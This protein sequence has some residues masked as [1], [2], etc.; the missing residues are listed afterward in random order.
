M[1]KPILYD[2]PSVNAC[3][4]VKKEKKNP[5]NQNTHAKTPTP[6]AQDY[7]YPLKLVCT[8]PSLGIQPPSLFT[9]TGHGLIV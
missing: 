3:I 4:S 7:A 6:L 1:A 9:T 2:N 8:L 5:I